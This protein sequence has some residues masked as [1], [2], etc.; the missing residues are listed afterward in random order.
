MK[1]ETYEERKIEQGEL[2]ASI[3]KTSKKNNDSPYFK[4]WTIR[5]LKQEAMAYDELIYGR[6]PCYG[7][8][9]IRTLDG[10][11]DEL[12]ER[13]VEFNNQLTFN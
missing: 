7:V 8:S 10:I 11:L 13:G 2:E 1:T 12:S 9:D 4:D 6:M 3:R 5:K